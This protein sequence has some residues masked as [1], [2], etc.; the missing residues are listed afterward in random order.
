[1]ET[2][3]KLWTHES[4]EMIS[5]LLVKAKIPNV[6][7]PNVNYFFFLQIKILLMQIDISELTSVFCDCKFLHPAQTR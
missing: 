2:T 5:T 7:F 6:L 1:M 3:A 4:H